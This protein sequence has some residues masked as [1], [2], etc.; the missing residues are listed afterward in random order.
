MI[1]K[2]LVHE[3]SLGIFHP[4]RFEIARPKDGWAGLWLRPWCES[5]HAF[6]AEGK[7]CRHGK[8]VAFMGSPYQ[9]ASETDSRSNTSMLYSVRV[10][11]GSISKSFF[12][13]FSK[14]LDYCSN[15]LQLQ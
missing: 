14:A 15:L 3:D 12:V 10:S 8:G 6:S 2:M 4:S 13:I 11:Q 9:S 1:V 7:G 5:M